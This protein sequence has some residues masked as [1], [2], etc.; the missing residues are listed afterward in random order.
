MSIPAQM[1]MQQILDK[2]NRY[3]EKEMKKASKIHKMQIEQEKVFR[4]LNT[5]ILPDWVKMRYPKVLQSR[6]IA[7]WELDIMREYFIIEVETPKA[8]LIEGLETM[9]EM[10]PHFNHSDILEDLLRFLLKN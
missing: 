1:A 9:L 5:A 3:V 10:N 4:L 7:S 6:Q 2:R 8:Y